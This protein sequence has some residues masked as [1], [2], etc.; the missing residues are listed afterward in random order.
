MNSR[1]TYSSLA[2]AWAGSSRRGCGWSSQGEGVSKTGEGGLSQDGGSS[3]VSRSSGSPDMV[4]S[5]QVGWWAI[6][7]ISCRLAIACDYG[8]W[9]GSWNVNGPTSMEV[10]STR[11]RF[12][13]A[14][15][16]EFAERHR[17]KDIWYVRI[18]FG[19]RLRSR[20]FFGSTSCGAAFCVALTSR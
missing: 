15:L 12:P 9:I 19:P 7:V 6:T 1:W 8:A 18:L 13:T 10:N 16:L 11:F 17:K 5:L 14:G 3:N 2:L 20:D 4:Q